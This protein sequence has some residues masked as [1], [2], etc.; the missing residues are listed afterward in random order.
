MFLKP[1]TRIDVT[2][3]DFGLRQQ[4]WAWVFKI[5]SDDRTWIVD[6]SGDVIFS[7]KYE[8][9]VIMFKLKFGV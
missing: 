5:N 8:E 4:M 7:F 9:D 6:G 1:W 3:A 2:D